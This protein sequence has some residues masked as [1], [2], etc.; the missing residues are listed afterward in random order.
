MIRIPPV[1]AKRLE[2]DVGHLEII[3][4]QEDTAERI[5]EA[6]EGMRKEGELGALILDLRGNGGGLLVQATKILDLFVDEGELVVVRSVLGREHQDAEKSVRWPESLPVVV[7]VDEGSASAS[8]VLGGGIKELGRGIVLGRR[9]FGKGT[10]QRLRPWKGYGQK[11]ALKMTIA[12]YRV[13][14]ERQIQTVGLQPD[15]ELIPVQLSHIPGV[16]RYYDRERFERSRSHSM[17]AHLP[18]AIHDAGLDAFLSPPKLSL[19]FLAESAK[20][21]EELALAREVAAAL[22]AAKVSKRTDALELLAEHSRSLE[23]RERERIEQAIERWKVDWQLGAFDEA[24]RVKEE[25]TLALTLRAKNPVATLAGKPFAIE[26]EV[27][28][29]SEKAVDRVRAI[30]D[31][32]ADEL[33]G[34][35]VLFGR[36]EA[37]EKAKRTIELQVFPWRRRAVETLRVSV[38]GHTQVD[39]DEISSEIFFEIEEAKRPAF[40]FDHWIVDDPQRVASAPKRPSSPDAEDEPFAVKGN[41]DGALQAGERVLLAVRVQNRGTGASESAKLVVR[42][43]SVRQGQLEEGMVELGTIKPGQWREGAVGFGLSPDAD[44]DQ[45][46]ELELAVVDA[47]LRAQTRHRVRFRLRRPSEGFQAG[48]PSVVE[49][50]EDGG[51]LYAAA[52]GKAPVVSDLKAGERV[53]VEGE[54]EG[55]WAVKGK[56]GRRYWLPQDLAKDGRG[57]AKS[58]LADGP[59]ID[60]PT[61]EVEPLPLRVEGASVTIVGKARAREGVHDLVFWVT[62]GSRTAQREKAAYLVNPAR[63]TEG[64]REMAFSQALSLS[65]G[66]NRITISARNEKGVSWTEDF[67]VYR[68]D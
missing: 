66:G 53:A 43:L 63:D 51:R 32:L 44:L 35:E 12:E 47:R 52:D 6:V 1:K 60:P 26:V 25:G 11:L 41:G 8:E 68:G 27:E 55:W 17:T 54:S 39:S 30:T 34:I 24:K 18:S 10:V 38:Q 31:C 3:A 46:V 23:A 22:A 14:G 57:K 21:D 13:A 56:G 37:G 4:F 15:L 40:A 64:A 45:Y 20:K 7:L 33:D 50:G 48:A 16:A 65:P 49:I 28:N 36:I 42:N 29:R 19:D 62:G 2:G 58:A 67:W 61:L 59:T 9:S 5:E